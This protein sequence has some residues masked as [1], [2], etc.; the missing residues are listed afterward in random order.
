[1]TDSFSVKSMADALVADKHRNGSTK[2]VYKALADEHKNEEIS[3][4]IKTKSSAL[5]QAIDAPKVNLSDTQQVQARTF[6]YLEAC[7]IASCF[8]S[9]MGLSGAMGF[10]RQNLYRWL[11]AHPDHPTTDFVNM[12]RDAIADV[13]TDASLHNNANAVQVIFT[14]KNWH[15]HADKVEIAPVMHR[16]VDDEEVSVDEIRKRYMLDVS[17]DTEEE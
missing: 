11:L 15:D 1:M 14:L 8:P 6:A 4:S 5:R 7:E 17:T 3:L 9:V 10:S 16:P 13:L 12:V 2:K